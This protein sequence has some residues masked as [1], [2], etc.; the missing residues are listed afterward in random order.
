MTDLP[1]LPAYLHRKFATLGA[2]RHGFSDTRAAA[3]R[4]FHIDSHSVVVRALQLLAEDGRVDADA[5]ARR[6]R[7]T[8]CS[9]CS[10]GA[11]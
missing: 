5:T 11:A 10:P 6:R 9:T 1:D 3:R 8:S 4:C 7:S 2:D